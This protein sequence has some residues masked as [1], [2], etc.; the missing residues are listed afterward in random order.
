MG[1][2]REVKLRIADASGYERLAHSLSAAE[3]RLQRNTYF[4]TPDLALAKAGILVRVRE[5]EGRVVLAV[6][7]GLARATGRI[8]SEEWEKKL[9][10]KLWDAVRTGQAALTTVA[11]F[12][13]LDDAARARGFAGRFAR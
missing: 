10:L 8:E 6:K 11:R 7:R 12:A 3:A 13:P 4:D 1:L 5:E 2:E 9:D